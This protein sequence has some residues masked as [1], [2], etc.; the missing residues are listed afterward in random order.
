M[1]GIFLINKEEGWTSFDICAKLRR[2]FN[3]KKVGHCGTL[4]PF[5]EGL[6]I[7]C[8]GEMTKIIP[9][10]ENHQKTYIATIR[11][12]QETDTLDKT[13]HITLEKAVPDFSI[14]EINDILKSFIGKSQQLP[15]MFSALKKDGVPLYALAR[16]GIEIERKLRDIEI[17]SL[18]IIDYQKPYLT[19]KTRVSKGTYIRSLGK[20][21]AEK[22]NTV[23]HLVSLKRIEIDKFNLADSKKV[24]EISLGDSK[25]IEEMLSFLPTK[26]CSLEE[27]QKIRNGIRLSLDK[28]DL[29]YL[30]TKDHQPLA[31]YERRSDGFYYT[32]RGLFN[33]NN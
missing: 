2:M 9:F 23:G 31:I 29:V 30:M 7:V 11:L 13:G 5:A 25:T 6:M 15:P 21:I 22:M 17:F 18:E 4:D 3:T 26:I 24:S 12:G 8:L 14:E 27:E 33:G 19:I 20:D 28:G 1:N 16:E 32:K 10:L